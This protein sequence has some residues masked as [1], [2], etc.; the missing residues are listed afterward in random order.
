MFMKNRKNSIYNCNF[1]GKVYEKKCQLNLHVKSHKTKKCINPLRKDDPEIV[2]DLPAVQQSTPLA[3]AS[4]SKDL[5][6]IS[7]S[8]DSGNESELEK[9]V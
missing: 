6:D 8:E 5:L 3:S 9:E 1:C 7:C 2:I 4:C